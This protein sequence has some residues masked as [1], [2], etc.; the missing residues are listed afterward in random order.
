MANK[1]SLI[2]YRIERA[3]QTVIEAKFN[4]ENGFLNLTENRV[5]YAMF[6][7]VSALALKYDFVTSKHSVLKG[8]FNKEFIFTKKIDTF[9]YKIYNRAFERRQEGD[10]DDFITFEKD[11]VELDLQNMDIFLVEIFRLIYEG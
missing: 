4:F 10:Y 1:N 3:K 11:E 9:Y 2:D 6:Y 5:Y 8:W 7:A